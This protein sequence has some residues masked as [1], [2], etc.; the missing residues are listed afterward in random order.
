MK[1]GNEGKD[2]QGVVGTLFELF[3]TT[4]E[5]DCHDMTNAAQ[6]LIEKHVPRCSVPSY[7]ARIVAKRIHLLLDQK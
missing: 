3:L 1:D 4:L 6:V 7:S 2:Y 5:Q